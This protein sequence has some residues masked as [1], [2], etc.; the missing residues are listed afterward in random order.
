MI[1]RIRLPRLD[2]ST[3]VPKDEQSENFDTNI[4]DT[5]YPLIVPSSKI[6][7]KSIRRPKTTRSS[8][9]SEKFSNL[10]KEDNNK[11][12]VTPKCLIKLPSVDLTH[13]QRRKSSKNLTDLPQSLSPSSLVQARPQQ[14]V[15]ED[16]VNQL[17]QNLKYL[18]DQHKLNLTAL[19]Q[20][21]ELLRQQNRDLQFQLVFDCDS[22][23]SS[24]KNTS[25]ESTQSK[26]EVLER[27]LDELSISFDE[28]KNENI[29]LKKIIEK[30]KKKFELIK[31]N[32]NNKIDIGIQVGNTQNDFVALLKISKAMVQLVKC[33]YDNREK[34]LTIKS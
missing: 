33:E 18:Q 9:S 4:T 11:F 21:V 34:K 25:N 2:G 29:K 10:P 12:S 16:R 14:V 17:E 3:R 28:V 31:N 27:H 15:K 30:E 32:E 13:Y 24:L 20:E 1:S 23:S 7:L 6:Q 8:Y 19:H 26:V 22:N 5:F